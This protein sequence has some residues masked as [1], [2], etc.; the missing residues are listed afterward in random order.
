MQGSSQRVGMPGSAGAWLKA[1][2]LSANPGRSRCINDRV[3]P[4]RACKRI[5]RSTLCRDRIRRSDFHAGPPIHLQPLNSLIVPTKGRGA[6]ICS[7]LTQ[8]D[9]ARNGHLPQSTGSPQ[10]QH[11]GGSTSESWTPS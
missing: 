7:A 1:D 8:R 2:T 3:V 9:Y 4:D 5:R 11:L 6:G 10:L